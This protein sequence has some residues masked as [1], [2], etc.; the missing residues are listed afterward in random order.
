MILKSLNRLQLF[1]MLLT[2][3]TGESLFSLLRSPLLVILE[4][5]LAMLL[6]EDDL[7]PAVITSS[8]VLPPP[9]LL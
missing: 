3:L 6:V 4:P 1:K 2:I 8:T 5:L 9:D 7:L